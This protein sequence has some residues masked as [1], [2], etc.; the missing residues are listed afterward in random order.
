MNTWVKY[1][2]I[3]LALGLAPTLDVSANN[4]DLSIDALLDDIELKVENINAA[5]IDDMDFDELELIN[6]SKNW[7]PFPKNQPDSKKGE[8]IRWFFSKLGEPERI[9]DGLFYLD[10]NTPLYDIKTK[11]TFI[12]PRP[13]LVHGRINEDSNDL[14]WIHSKRE[15]AFRYRAP[16]KDTFRARATLDIKTRPDHYETYPAPDL[17]KALDNSLILKTSLNIHYGSPGIDY[18]VDRVADEIADAYVVRYELASHLYRAFR[19][20][21]GLN[22]NYERGALS[23]TNNAKEDNYF[24]SLN[25]GPSIRFPFIKTSAF[26][27]S[28][29]A[30]AQKSLFYRILSDSNGQNAIKF[31]NYQGQVSIEGMFKFKGEH[32]LA[33][34]SWTKQWLHYRPSRESELYT[35]D[36]ESVTTNQWAGIYLGW[37]HWFEI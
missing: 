10:E 4:D 7:R 24:H 9:F 17:T 28:A 25:V 6:Q 11:K 5:D 12:M 14:I 37:E 27:L 36:H 20:E 8:Q 15:D 21:L 1:F 34:L 18:L 2:S 29:T 26:R 3:V 23:F 16:A 19:A 13:V 33:G 22:L 35:E 30:S 32:F 31:S